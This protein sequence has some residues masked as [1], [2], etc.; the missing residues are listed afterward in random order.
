MRQ[1]AAQVAYVDPWNVLRNHF[2]SATLALQTT[3]VRGWMS[4]EGPSPRECGWSSAANVESQPYR[5]LSAG[6]CASAT[7]PSN[8]L[9]T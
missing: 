8:A 7:A 4:K 5:L 6:T 2:F 1:L 3:R 9:C